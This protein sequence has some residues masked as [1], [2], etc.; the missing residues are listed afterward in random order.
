MDRSRG[1]RNLSDEA[2]LLQRLEEVE[3]PPGATD[4]ERVAARAEAAAA[5]EQAADEMGEHW[6]RAYQ[7]LH[8]DWQPTPTDIEISNQR[9]AEL[10]AARAEIARL[11]AAV[12]FLVNQNGSDE[13]GSDEDGPYC[14]SMAHDWDGDVCKACGTTRERWGSAPP[15]AARRPETDTLPPGCP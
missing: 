2:R 3:L 13:D 15:Y 14:Q 9:A 12:A 7:E 4:A 10:T 5:V 1:P 11:K 6:A 8:P